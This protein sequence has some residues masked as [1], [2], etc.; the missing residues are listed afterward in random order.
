MLRG[1]RRG[2][3]G[4]TL[5]DPFE[6]ARGLR[7]VSFWW[8]SISFVCWGSK[9]H[10]ATGPLPNTSAHKLHHPLNPL[11]VIQ[12]HVCPFFFEADSQAWKHPQDA[13]GCGKVAAS[14][15]QSHQR[16]PSTSFMLRPLTRSAPQVFGGNLL[17]ARFWGLVQVKW[18]EEPY[19][20]YLCKK[21]RSCWDPVP[22][23]LPCLRKTVHDFFTYQS[24]RNCSFHGA[25]TGVESIVGQISPGG[26]QTSLEV[27][28]PRSN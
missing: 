1:P 8:I 12:S 27:L 5:E 17:S 19:L 2:L 24:L 18:P 16:P 13:F 6:E 11:N 28:F 25:G 20:T 7:D 10:G 26:A 3:G 23:V 14:L 4:W 9:Q 22:R 15:G 21:Y